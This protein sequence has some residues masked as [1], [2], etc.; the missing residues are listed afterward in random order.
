[1]SNE[2]AVPIPEDL[3]ADYV[4]LKKMVAKKMT[5]PWLGNIAQLNLIGRIAALTAEVAAKDA[6]IDALKGAVHA[7]VA[8]FTRDSAQIETMR[9]A[10]SGAEIMLGYLLEWAQS[11]REFR[12]NDAETRN[13]KITLTSV[14]DALAIAAPMCAPV[15]DAELTEITIERVLRKWSD[16]DDTEGINVMSPAE[17][18]RI[19]AVDL[20]RAFAHAPAAPKSC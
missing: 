13:A 17:V 14:R 7:D 18:A 1:M 15:S 19:I 20:A 2:K 4:Q 5:L 11:N 12:A 16:V 8:E 10:L 6:A 3:Q 9:K